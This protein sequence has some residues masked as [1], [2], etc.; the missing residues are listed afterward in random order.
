VAP[1]DKLKGELKPIL[2]PM[3]DTMKATPDTGLQIKALD[4][5]RVW[6]AA[7]AMAEAFAGYRVMTYVLPRDTDRQ[8]RLER[9]FR[10]CVRAALHLGG[11]SIV[12]TADERE[13]AAGAVIW[14][15]GARFPI[16][17]RALFTSGMILTPLRIGLAAFSRLETHEGPAES[18]IAS[19]YSGTRMAY[20]W[21]IG[22]TRAARGQGVGRR[23]ITQTLEQM[24]SAD[25]Q[26]CVLKTDTMEN[27]RLYEHLGFTVAEHVTETTSGLDYWILERRL[28][29]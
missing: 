18:R 25:Y 17:P 26:V 5:S 8:R 4:S 9:M 29:G 1:P 14:I 21:M 23:L 22:T 19:R 11:G 27:V 16:R 13:P 7:T 2:V 10:S 6:P 3:K 28:D 24:R 12:D 15:D 20:L